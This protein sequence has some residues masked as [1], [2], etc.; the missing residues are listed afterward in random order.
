MSNEFIEGKVN[1]NEY[2]TNK[3]G[4]GKSVFQTPNVIQDYKIESKTKG[5]DKY[6]QK[7]KYESTIQN[8]DKDRDRDKE[9]EYQK[10][11]QPA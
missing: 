5:N 11:E 1:V 4:I 10:E 3:K 9:N 2:L 8:K 7:L 6:I